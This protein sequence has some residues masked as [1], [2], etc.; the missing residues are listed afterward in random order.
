VTDKTISLELLGAQVLTLTDGT[1]LN[2][3]DQGVPLDQLRE[4]LCGVDP[5][6][7]RQVMPLVGGVIT[8][9]FTDIVDSTRVKHEVGD[10]TYFAALNP[11]NNAVRKCIA[12][13]AG[14]ELKMI[15]DSFFV[16]FTDPSKAV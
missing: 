16:A 12:L 10:P 5:E 1:L 14:H 4:L 7:L 11:H 6:Q 3:L 8:M 2:M 15:G 9:M 13:H